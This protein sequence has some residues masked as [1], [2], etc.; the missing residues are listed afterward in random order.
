MKEFYRSAVVKVVEK[1]FKGE[2]FIE[3]ACDSFEIVTI[4]L[5]DEEVFAEFGGRNAPSGYYIATEGIN[6]FGYFFKAQTLYIHKYG[7]GYKRVARNSERIDYNW[8]HHYTRKN[9]QLLD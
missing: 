5:T 9:F 4:D 1:Y 6:L 2:E 3:E 7:R 8:G